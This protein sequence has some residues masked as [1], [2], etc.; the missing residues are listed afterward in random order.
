[1]RRADGRI[2]HEPKGVETGAPSRAALLKPALR[3]RLDA[4]LDEGQEIWDR[5][6]TEVRAHRFHP[7]VPSDYSRVLEVLLRLHRPGL[8]FLEWG[9]ATGVITIM[10][11]LIGYEG[12]GIEIDPELIDIARGLAGRFESGARFASGSFLP[13]GYRYRP[14]KGDGRLGTIA[15]GISAYPE[16]QHPLEDFDVVFGYPWSGEEPIMHDLFRCHGRADARLVLQSATGVEAYLGGQ[17][18]G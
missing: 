5:F 10:A 14:R 13:T 1:M 2:G 4:L 18:A 17:L 15:R 9:S 12:Y 6:D 7:F 11:D 8:R 3:A 16:L